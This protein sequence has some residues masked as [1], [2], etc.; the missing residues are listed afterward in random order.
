MK[1]VLKQ[2]TKELAQ[3]LKNLGIKGY[4]NVQRWTPP[5][6]YDGPVRQDGTLPQIV[7]NLYSQDDANLLKISYNKPDRLIIKIAAV[8][9][10]GSVQDTCN[11]TGVGT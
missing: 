1:Q 11:D 10:D 5:I 7:F 9:K 8:N 3:I 2:Y 4:V 6:D